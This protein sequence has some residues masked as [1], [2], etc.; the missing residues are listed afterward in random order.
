MRNILT[1]ILI[2]LVILSG[3]AFL[4]KPKK[5]QDGNVRISWLTPYSQARSLQ[6]EEFNRQH[7]GIILTADHAF[8]WDDLSK[9][10]IQCSTGLGPDLYDS[11]CGS[12]IQAY[13]ESGV[14]MD[15]T[16]EARANGF[17]KEAMWPGIYD[18]L[19]INGRQ[20]AYSANVGTSVLGYNKNV[21]DRFHLPYPKQDMTWEECFDLAKKLTVAGQKEDFVYGLFSPNWNDFF[22][23]LRGEYF[24]KDGTIILLDTEVMKRAVQ[25]HWA[26]RYQWG[27]TPPDLVARTLASQGGEMNNASNFNLFADGHYAMYVMGNWSLIYF[28]NVYDAQK[29]K[30]EKWNADPHRDPRN[31][32]KLLRLGSVMIPHFQGIPRGCKLQSRC[33]VV[34][35]KSPNRESAVK[36]LKYLAGPEYSAFIV[37]ANDQLPPNPAYAKFTEDA[38]YHD[39]EE[40]EMFNN[41]AQSMQYAYLNIRSPFLLGSEITRIMS[42]QISRLEA[43]PQLSIDDLLNQ[44]Q[45]AAEEQMQRTLDRNPNLKKK[46]EAI[47]GTSDVHQA[48][49]K[50]RNKPSSS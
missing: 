28:E 49:R 10:I 30:W 3:V 16:E 25:T 29:K 32:P 6:V 9:V 35:S 39:L 18:A 47:Q 7:P 21:F 46:Y 17:S 31:E 45:Y 19:T 20:Y 26:T 50:L 15:V 33:V 1:G 12:Q 48:H 13:V 5:P 43:N 14:A 8:R 36:L 40:E 44:A 34:N 42:Q 11:D 2:C 37:K 41:T 24:S 22:A 4:L 38:K 27:I 23:S